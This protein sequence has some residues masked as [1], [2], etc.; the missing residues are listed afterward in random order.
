MKEYWLSA[1]YYSIVTFTVNAK[2]KDE[3]I[4]KFRQDFEVNGPKRE[5]KEYIDWESLS[6]N[7]YDADEYKERVEE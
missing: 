7:G 6:I 2:N 5:R 3:A 1:H 4:D